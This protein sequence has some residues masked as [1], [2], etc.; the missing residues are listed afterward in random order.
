MEKSFENILDLIDCIDEENQL[1]G[2]NLLQNYPEEFKEHW[3]QAYNPAVIKVIE[4]SIQR[5]FWVVE[6]TPD[7]EP[8]SKGRNICY[9][10]NNEKMSY[11]IEIKCDSEKFI[12]VIDA[13][14]EVPELANKIESVQI[15]NCDVEKQLESF[16]SREWIKNN[17]KVCWLTHSKIQRLPENIQNCQALEYLDLSHNHLEE[18]SEFLF[19]LQNL[20]YLDMSSNAIQGFSK[21]LSKLKKLKHLN[22][23]QGEKYSEGKFLLLHGEEEAGGVPDEIL[24][25]QSLEY[26]RIDDS[27]YRKSSSLIQSFVCAIEKKTKKL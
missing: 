4:L 8:W 6:I 10:W 13:I 21:G 3:G 14:E 26:L 18:I 23:R 1:L 12:E 24:Q 2:A 20:A 7:S 11:G 17:L 9:R 27:C 22:L 15:F 16:F 25:L 19:E 5:L